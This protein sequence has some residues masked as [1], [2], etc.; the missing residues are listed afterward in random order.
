MIRIALVIIGVTFT[1]ISARA[2]EDE[3]WL[4]G[5]LNHQYW[6][7]ADDEVQADSE[8]I[9]ELY[10]EATDA[11][12]ED[13]WETAV[14]KF[15]AV[16]AAQSRLSDGALYWKAYSLAKLGQRL[17]ALEAL[18]SF[19]KTSPPSRWSREAKALELEIRQASGQTPPPEAESDDELKLVVISGLMN[20]NPERALPLLEKVLD[21]NASLKIKEHALFVLSQSGSPR[22]HE[23]LARVAT[24][25]ANPDLQMRAIEYLGLYGGD[26]SGDLLAEIFTKSTEIE[27]KRKILSSFMLSGDSERLYRIAQT[28]KDERLRS[29]A[30]QQLGLMG[31][32]QRLWK[33]YQTEP[34][35]DLRKRII[36][37]LFLGG[38]AELLISVARTERDPELRLTAIQQL[39]L[40][41]KDECGEALVSLYQEGKTGEEREAI[42]SSLWLQGNVDALVALAR[43][44]KDPAVKRTIVEK[45]SLMGSDKATEYMI[46][47]LEK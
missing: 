28:E 31:D 15:N 9:Q 1:A 29:D 30:I 39:G 26:Q 16:V 10:E 47:L 11:L 44:E 12:N 40:V 4:N 37:S 22:S 7:F 41:G 33:L 6:A 18:S 19:R 45:L 2:S 5:S 43:A 20:T 3:A 34:S 21:G 24:G 23:I 38:N 32:H 35:V 8:R 46:E 17:K 13:R 42:L 27:V 36:E 25:S 14:E